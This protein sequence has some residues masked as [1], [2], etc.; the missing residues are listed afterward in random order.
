MY[1]N[2][3]TWDLAYTDPNSADNKPDPITGVTKSKSGISKFADNF[4]RH[5]V[6]GTEI[7]IAKALS[8]RAG[9]NYKARQE[10][11]LADRK[12]LSG[13]SYGLGLR[14]KMFNFSYTRLI[15]QPGGL[16]PNYISFA[17]NLGAFS[18]KAK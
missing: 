12:A 5:I 13:F 6:L 10:M 9:Y 18:K 11:K 16:N 14:I 15:Y 1:N 8:L 2:I 3:E 7:T 4:M 17:M